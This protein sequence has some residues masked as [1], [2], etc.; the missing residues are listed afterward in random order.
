MKKSNFISLDSLSLQDFDEN[1]ELIPLMTPEDEEKIAKEELPESLPI[2][3]L[4]N[5]VLFP[6]VVIP[7]TAGRDKSIKLINDANKGEKVIGVVSQI[8]EEVE[9]PKA[10][11]LHQVGTVARILKVLKMPDGN[12]TVIIQ[13]KKRFEIDTVITEEPYIKATVKEVPQATPAKKNKEF[14]AIID[15][16][17]ELAVQIIKDSPNIPTEATF[18]IKNIKSDAFLINFVSSNMNLSV[19][20]KQ[21]LLE[22]N[23]LKERALET[24]RFMNVEFQKLE[25]KNDI[26]SKV[27]SDLNQQQR[28]YF[29]NQQLKTIQ[30]ELG[31]GNAEEI[32]A[33]KKRAKTKKWDK[34]VKEHF[35]KELAKI[36]RMNPQVAEYSIQR[37]YLDLFLDLPWGKFSKDKF[38]LKRAEKILD[39][40]HYGLDDVKKRIIE[41]LAVLKLRNDMK[42]PIICLYGPPGVGKTSLGK[43]VAEALGREYVRMSLGGLRDEAEIRGHRKTY[44]GAMPGRIL[45]SLK[46]A[47]TSNPVFVLD[48]IDK[49]SN[50][51]QGDPSSALLEVLDPEQNSEFHDNFLEMGYD[52]SKVMFIATTNSLNTIQP[53]L[54]DRMEIIN[55]TGYTIEEK[56]EIA[57]RHL[58]P[59]QLK[60]HGLTDKHIKIAKPQLE[61]IVEGYTRESGVRGLEK[62]IAKMVRYAAKNIAMEQD[63]NIKIS[64]DDIIEILG[65]PKL[66][67]DK[68]ENNNVAGVVTGLAWTRVGGDILFIESILSKGKGSLNITGNLGKVMKESSTIAMEYIKAHA[69][70]LGIDPDVFEKYNVHIHVP[71]GATPKDGP[72]AGVTMLTSLVSLFTQRKVKKSLAMTGEI[73]LRGKVLPVGGIKEKILAA[74]R[75]KIKEILLCEDNRRDIEEIKPEY[76]NGL[77]FHY[78]SD[79]LEVVDIAITDQK[80]KNAKKL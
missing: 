67:R 22:I 45:Q 51:N 18:A 70:E 50:S 72:S 79:M 44:I 34:K 30:E 49:L 16:I 38:D 1:S 42:S 36:Q 37:N 33:M 65:G 21:A 80:V 24:L 52:L 13:G 76:L 17:K 60:E 5:T 62:Q 35:E 23:D 56:V 61:K 2:L 59:K 57:K 71:E 12:T 66:E 14:A 77:T 4:R 9:D 41:H 20:E 73:T 58:L 78:V 43:S 10:E 74:K 69:E 27:Q 7:I 29:L 15:S 39:R 32:E 53:A 6:G 26:Q 25:L 63:Y 55:V 3:S 19:D 8:D 64:N 11:E 40:D 47:G 54:R 48:E 75:A 28:E 68:Y 46:K 31:G